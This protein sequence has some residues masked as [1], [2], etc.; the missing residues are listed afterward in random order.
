MIRAIV[1][2]FI[3][4]PMPNHATNSG[5]RAS[6]GIDRLIWMGP[7]MSASPTRKSPETTARTTPAS[8]PRVRPRAERRRDVPMFPS[9]SWCTHWSWNSVTTSHGAVSTAALMNPA[10][11]PT[12]QTTSRSTGPAQ[13]DHR[14]R[15]P[16]PSRRLTTRASRWPPPWAAAAARA[17]SSRVAVVAA[18]TTRL[19][20]RRRS[21]RQPPRRRR[22]GCPR[23]PRRR[24]S[25]CPGR[26][27]IGR[28]SSGAV[29]PRCPRS[30]ESP[31]LPRP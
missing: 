1:V 24:T 15:G 20:S 6:V 29:T 3:S 26:T 16:G 8:T 4:S 19:L 12:T 7:S 9:R 25:G 10:F 22:T 30:R 28:R 23:S 11:E 31:W 27:P 14:V 5:I 17:T 13:K 18:V 2:T 21:P